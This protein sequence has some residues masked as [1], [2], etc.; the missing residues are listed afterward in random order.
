MKL[1]KVD[2]QN[3]LQEAFSYVGE[4]VSHSSD[5]T[6]IILEAGHFSSSYGSDQ[7][8]IN[9]LKGALD[10]ANNLIVEYGREI[11]VVLALLIDD[12]GL[13]CDV[14]VCSV[15][16]N[17]GKVT[18]SFPDELTFILKSSP[19]YNVKQFVISSERAAKNR[20]I[21]KLKSIIKKSDPALGIIFKLE[22]ENQQQKFFFCSNDGQMV[23]LADIKDWVW[24]SHCSLIMGQHYFDLHKKISRR[25]PYNWPQI[26]IDFSS[27]YERGKVNRG[28][29]LA[30]QFLSL[31]GLSRSYEIVNIC[32]ADEEGE[33]YTIDHFNIL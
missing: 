5:P 21:A 29:E 9:T 20:G 22:E 25:Y 6:I 10:L 8:A 4:K 1:Q 7:H 14:D 23:L 19:I 33:V 16:E 11:K 31:E 17:V 13:S 15:G 3:S 18:G 12:L 28:A 30:I 32:F 24:R 27:I 26:L 2:I